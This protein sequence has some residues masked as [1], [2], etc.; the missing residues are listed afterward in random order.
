M[1]PSLSAEQQRLTALR[2]TGLLDTPP[3]EEFDRITRLASRLFGVPIALV[4]L[5]DADRQWFKSQVGLPVRETCRE[6]AFCDHTIRSSDVMVVENALEDPR[7]AANPLVAGPP[8]IRFYAGAPLILRGHHHLGSLCLIDTVPRT[9][10]A[11]QQRQLE[12]LAALV[13]AQ[14]DLQ[15]SASRLDEATLLP[16]RSQLLQDLDGLC[17]AA[18]GEGRILALLELLPHDGLMDAVRAVGMQPIEQLTY[19][20]GKRLS[21]FLGSQSRI[22]HTGVARLAM[23]LRTAD[24][25]ALQQFTQ[26]L[27]QTLIAPLSGSGIV[28]NQRRRV[29][30]APFTLE[31]ADALDALRRANA[32]LY[33]QSVP[34]TAVCTYDAT[35]DLSYRRS[36]ELM[37]SVPRALMAGEF[38]LVYQPQF[39]RASTRYTCVEALLR[40][41]HPQLGPVSPGDFIPLLEKTT[42]IQAVTEWVLHTALA[43]IR[44]WEDAGL[45][46][47]VAINVSPRNLE[48]PGFAGM[49]QDAFERHGLAPSRLEIECTENAVLT[50]GPTLE[51]IKAARAL[52][53]R[54]A[55][56]D[57]GTGYCNFGCLY[58]LS[59][60]V[61]KL[62]QALIRPI[63]TDARA[64]DVVRGM[65]QLGHTLGYRLLAEGV[66]TAEVFDQLMELG[67][68]QVQGYY[69]SRPLPPDQAFAFVRRWNQLVTLEQD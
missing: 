9:F 14:I 2:A 55:L 52:G 25:H 11:S 18:P 8:H 38:R 20:A 33:H 3:T 49:L 58:D 26:Q 24:E 61:L 23:V 66:E 22:Y 32:A 56:D 10:D 4:S 34:D 63:G 53:V 13:M 12:D 42:Y 45:E 44:A 27:L 68:D 28:I 35:V 31:P 17:R 65:V 60:E 21:F 54:V 15:C 57:F 41:D 30:L 59:A 5:V 48:Q 7:F 47:D 37:A 19:E 36:Y 67:C 6:D 16:N 62:D 64:L 50:E 51:G 43:Q 1:T 69:L 29:G 39:E 40:W 46:V